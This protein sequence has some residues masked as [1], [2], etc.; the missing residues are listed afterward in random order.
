[1]IIPVGLAGAGFANDNAALPQNGPLDP[2]GHWRV[3][4]RGSR[5]SLGILPLAIAFLSFPFSAFAFGQEAGAAFGPDAQAR[6]GDLESAGAKPKPAATPDSKPGA[7]ESNPRT[8]NSSN[9]ESRISVKWRAGKLSVSAGGAPLAA[10]LR[11]VA[12]QTGMEVRGS[13]ML[14]QQAHVEFSGVPLA[15]ALQDLLAGADYAVLGDVS[16]PQQ[17][18]PATLVIFDSHGLADHARARTGP[19]PADIRAGSGGARGSG[20]GADAVQPSS[21]VQVDEEELVRQALS[22]NPNVQAAAFEALAALDSGEAVEAL[23]AAIKS[24]EPPARLQALQLLDHFP[25]ADADTV[26]SALGTALTDNDLSVKLFAIQALASR[27]GAEAMNLLNQAFNSADSSVR[28]MVLQS[29]SGTK[30]GN[31]LLE[32]ATSDP[33]QAVAASASALLK[34]GD[35]SIPQDLV[36]PDR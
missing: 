13:E 11:E 9:L 1:V 18:R 6:A 20:G 14:Q 19:R 8:E 17:T 21:V 28:L 7:R 5:F 12:C 24:G 35:S 27:G 16:S 36:M 3:E 29:V 22:S 4:M 10:I 26:V 33:D 34:Q 31:P 25:Q 30:E 2:R 23:E 15:E 32:H